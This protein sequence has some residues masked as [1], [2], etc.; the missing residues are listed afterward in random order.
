MWKYLTPSVWM[1]SFLHSL[2]YVCL[3]VIITLLASIPAAYAFFALEN[4]KGDHQLFFWLLT[5]RMAP[6]VIFMV[7]LYSDLFL[8]TSI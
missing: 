2:E 1:G 3:N 4:L 8:S 5:N 7:P 6:A